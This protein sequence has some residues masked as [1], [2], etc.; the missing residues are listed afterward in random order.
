M[1]TKR[2]LPCFALL[3][4]LTLPS[5][6]AEPPAGT[7]IGA[8]GTGEVIVPADG[9]VLRLEV[10]GRGD[11][12]AAASAEVAV[13]LDALLAALRPLGD[14]VETPSS[15][16]YGVSPD[17][18]WDDDTDTEV[19]LGYVASSGLRVT[20]R[21]L[22]RLGAV[23]D[24]ALAGRADSVGRPE[25]TSSRQREARDRAL[26]LAYAQARR[27]AEVLARAAGGRLG[28]AVTLTTDPSGFRGGF[29]EEIT[30]SGAAP[31]LHVESP[32]VEVRMTV[33]G[34]WRVVAAE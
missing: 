8:K 32:Q 11:S 3:L 12:A 28:P 34:T 17:S 33:A 13:R 24:A 20:V 19:L 14:A 7:T 26:E 15:T 31:G 21:D 10:H 22:G 4:A 30:V 23:I 25:F 1:R 18:R 27:D 9:A 2:L 29:A 16:G 6:A 5:L